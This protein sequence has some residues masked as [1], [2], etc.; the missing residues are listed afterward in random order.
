MLLSQF[1]SPSP[2]PYFVYK[3]ILYVLKWITDKDLLYS[4][5]NF[6]QYYVTT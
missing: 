6:V 4:T 3:P 2:F 5:G 1:I